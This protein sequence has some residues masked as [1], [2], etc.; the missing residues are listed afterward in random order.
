MNYK[1][2]LALLLAIWLIVLSIAFIL[3]KSKPAVSLNAFSD[4][5][6]IQKCGYIRAG[7]LQNTTDYY[8]ENGTVKGFH[9]DLMELFGKDFNLKVNYAVYAD[10][11]DYFWALMTDEIDVLAMDINTYL[12]FTVFFLHNDSLYWAV[13][14][15]NSSLHLTLN[16]W[17]DSLTNTRLYPILLEKYYSP[18]SKNRKAMRQNQQKIEN[19]AISFDYDDLIKK[20]APKYG[21]DWRF[22]A[23]IIYQESGFNHRAIGKGNALGLM[24]IMPRTAAHIGMKNPY[25]PENQIL[26]GCKYLK[27]LKEKYEENGVDSADLYK[28]VLAAY[29]AGTCRIDDARLLAEKK[30]YNP[31]T[32]QD[33]EKMLVKLSDRK[34]TKNIPLYCGNYNGKFTKKYVSKVWETYLHYQNM[35]E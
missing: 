23:A 2:K 16:N 15:Q 29:N 12:P 25:L 3:S 31:N 11:W 13:N 17:L 4:W 26:Y 20:Y 30:G 22:V 7:I 32:W 10:Y 14:K 6:T 28:F 5:E 33:M 21:L 8:I 34:F 27:K 35:A 19:N 1:Q 9:Y 18:T 24:Q